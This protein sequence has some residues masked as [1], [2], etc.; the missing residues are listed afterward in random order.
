MADAQENGDLQISYRKQLSTGHSN[1]NTVAI[2]NQVEI[3]NRLAGESFDFAKVGIIEEHCRDPA[4]SEI[5]NTV[6]HSS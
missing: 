2:F 5:C 3:A 6:A 4:S 1:G